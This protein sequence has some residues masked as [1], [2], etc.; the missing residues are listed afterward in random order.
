MLNLNS[1]CSH[2]LNLF[3]TL[4]CLQNRRTIA[5]GRSEIPSRDNRGIFVV[6]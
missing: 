4:V 1:N 2:L 6:M 5:P 3:C